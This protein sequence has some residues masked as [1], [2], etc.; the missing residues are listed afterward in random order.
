[1]FM[2]WQNA[3]KWKAEEAKGATDIA[4]FRTA[5]FCFSTPGGHGDISPASDTT[6]TKPEQ[7]QQKVDQRIA[8]G[9]EYIKVMSNNGP[10]LPAMPKPVL[11]AI[12]KAA[13]KRGKMVVVH[14]TSLD[15]ADAGASGLAHLP[16]VKLPEPEWINA[17]TAHHMFV[18]TTMTFTDFHLTPGRLAAKL[19]DD[20][21]IRPYLG[22]AAL[23]A[24]LQLPQLRHRTSLVR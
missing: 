8:E 12:V 20:P 22:P 14:G 2:W 15:I 11:D 7:T 19:P 17:L 24:L 13:H 5:G 16:I 9:S 10:R 23:L 18:I 1:M 21:R 4:H 3:Q 6:I